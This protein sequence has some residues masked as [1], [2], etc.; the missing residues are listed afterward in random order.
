MLFELVLCF[1]GI[2]V[3]GDVVCGGRT[4]PVIFLVLLLRLLDLGIDGSYSGSVGWLVGWL[5]GRSV[6]T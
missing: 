1:V 4:T 3:I 5:I 2:V 6:D